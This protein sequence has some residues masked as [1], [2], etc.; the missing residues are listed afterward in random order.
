MSYEDMRPGADD[1]IALL[2]VWRFSPRCQL[3]APLRLLNH[4]PPDL[5]AARRHPQEWWPEDCPFFTDRAEF[6]AAA[7]AAPEQDFATVGPALAQLPGELAGGRVTLHHTRL[8]DAPAWFKVCAAPR[9]CT[10]CLGRGLSP[11]PTN[12]HYPTLN[13]QT[14]TSCPI[15]CTVYISTDAI[16][17]VLT[18]LQELHA[19]MS[20]LIIFT[21]D[22]ASHI[23]RDDPKWEVVAAAVT[24]PDGRQCLVRPP[25]PSL[26]THPSDSP[27]APLMLPSLLVLLGLAATLRSVSLLASHCTTV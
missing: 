11:T 27:H 19:R 8:T 3:D 26:P 4:P 12:P 23:D 22:G 14:R 5:T 21:I 2:R 15:L 13:A 1:I 25:A 16:Y 6:L 20:P 7:G 10:S 18:Y 24:R 17:P 9:G